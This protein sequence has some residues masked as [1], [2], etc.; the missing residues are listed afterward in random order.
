MLGAANGNVQSEDLQL[1]SVIY[2]FVRKFAL[3]KTH[4]HTACLAIHFDAKNEI[5]H[6]YVKYLIICSM[7]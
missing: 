5:I 2:D 1:S 3:P 6:E 7:W 4:T